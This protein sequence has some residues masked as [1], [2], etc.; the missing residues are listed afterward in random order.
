MP[1]E[2]I[3]LSPKAGLTTTEFYLAV[4][5]AVAG[6]AGQAA[7]LVSEPWGSLLAMAST[8][9]YTLSRTFLKK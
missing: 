5:T 1:T 3:E 6:L 9:V 4:V 8:I 7:G 2:P